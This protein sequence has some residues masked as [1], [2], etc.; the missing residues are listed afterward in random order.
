MNN[1]TDLQLPARDP[2]I[3]VLCERTERLANHIELQ[4]AQ[5]SDL[6]TR[7]MAATRGANPTPYYAWA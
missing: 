2:H 5:L 3:A 7:L 6:K 4:R 1:Q